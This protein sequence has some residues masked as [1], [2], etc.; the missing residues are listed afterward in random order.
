M[1]ASN[2][3]VRVSGTQRLIEN[4]EAPECE[5]KLSEEEDTTVTE[6][7]GFC[8]SRNGRYFLLYEENDPEGASV[9]TT[10]RF[11]TDS[12]EV[13]RRGQVVSKIY[14]S[15]GGLDE[16]PYETPF[17]VI[18]LGIRTAQVSLRIWKLADQPETPCILA[19]A[20]YV[21]E[22]DHVPTAV[23]RVR[24]QVRPIKAKTV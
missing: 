7:A 3:W 19:E 4:P 18:Q 5:W 10:I 20:D 1:T 9:H 15:P 12:F 17:G 23:N 14:F 13:S 2:V 21:T 8:G 22:M 6:A 16:S 24:I 11:E